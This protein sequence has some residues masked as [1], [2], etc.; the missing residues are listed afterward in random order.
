MVRDAEK[1]WEDE[2]AELRAQV[3][4]V[5]SVFGR[6]RYNTGNIVRP[7]RAARNE[8]DASRWLAQAH[9]SEEIFR[10]Y[11]KLSHLTLLCHR[12]F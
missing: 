3:T 10:K 12:Q 1:R 2:K 7:K 5:L 4:M 6:S 9:R 8:N 11:E